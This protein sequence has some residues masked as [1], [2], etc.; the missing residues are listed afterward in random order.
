MFTKGDTKRI[1]FRF[2]SLLYFT[3]PYRKILPLVCQQFHDLFGDI[4]SLRLILNF[5][6]LF[7]RH[8]GTLTKMSK[9][10]KTILCTFVVDLILPLLPSEAF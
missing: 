6:Y 9:I 4:L 1:L 7:V 3:I 10:S 8:F 5:H 2:C